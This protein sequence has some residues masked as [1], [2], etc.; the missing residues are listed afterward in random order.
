MLRRSNRF[1]TNIQICSIAAS[2]SY[3]I[4]RQS[5]SSKKLILT[6][7]LYFKKIISLL[8]WYTNMKLLSFPCQKAI[9]LSK[10]KILY[11]MSGALN[12]HVAE[13]LGLSLQNF[14][15]WFESIRDVRFSY[16]KHSLTDGISILPIYNPTHLQIVFNF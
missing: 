4:V 10:F 3:R 6:T 16:S 14:L 9:H 5:A 15:R 2:P 1:V 12:C 11:K 13:C 8:I 7:L